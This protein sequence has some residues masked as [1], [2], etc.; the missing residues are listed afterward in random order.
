MDK[1]H[2]GFYFIDIYYILLL[3]LLLLRASLYRCICKKVRGSVTDNFI[4]A[5]FFCFAPKDK[6]TLFLGEIKSFGPNLS[7]NKTK[8]IILSFM[9]VVFGSGQTIQIKIPS[10]IKLFFQY[11]LAVTKYAD[12]FFKVNLEVSSG[13]GQKQYRFRETNHR[14]N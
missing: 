11:L 8:L 5:K 10:K 1:D 4:Y 7:S 14:R 9:S 12:V 3:K 2:L 13:S 6:L